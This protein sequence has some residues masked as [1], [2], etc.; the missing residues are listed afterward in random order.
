MKASM[1][2]GGLNIISGEVTDTRKHEY[3][4]S[5]VLYFFF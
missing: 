4:R 3:H 5:I 1:P 2:K